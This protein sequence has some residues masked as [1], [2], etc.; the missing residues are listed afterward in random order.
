[1]RVALTGGTGRLGREL[2]PALVRAGHAVAA[3]VRGAP[4]VAGRELPR[5]AGLEW[6]EG[7][8]ADGAALARLAEGAD[9]IVHA[10]YAPPGAGVDA[11]ERFV[12]E[13]VVAALRLFERTGAC[14]ARQLVLVSSLAVYGEDPDRDP[15]GERFER[16]EDFPLW[17]GELYGAHKAALEKLAVAAASS[18]GW[19]ISALRLGF[20]L[21]RATPGRPDLLDALVE[22]ARAHG[23][24]RTPRGAYVVTTADA[25]EILAAAVGDASLAGAV[26]NV[27][28][29]WFDF[30]E[31]APLVAEHLGHPVA[32]RSPPAREPRAPIRND[33][34]LA[35]R[36]RLRLAEHL[37]ALV[38]ERVRGG[39]ADGGTA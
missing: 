28:E 3:L 22:E 17:P 36:P 18:Y 32:V 39:R 6:I 13:N 8:L 30:A 15:R 20:L 35:R 38:A 14:G 16:D 31:A 19:N 37:P 7:E 10:A 5:H 34:L 29:R 11:G 4:R 24:I 12:Q 23:E 9:A 26:L 27:H 33:R 25:A 2:V 1:V 21:G